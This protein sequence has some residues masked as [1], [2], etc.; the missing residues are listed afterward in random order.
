MGYGKLPR[1]LSFRGP[2]RGGVTLFLLAILRVT[3]FILLGFSQL[4]GRLHIPAPAAGQNVNPP[5]HIPALSEHPTG[6]RHPWL[7]SSLSSVNPQS[8]PGREG[9]KGEKEGGTEG[10]MGGRTEGRTE[11][12]K[13]LSLMGRLKKGPSSSPLPSILLGQVFCL[14]PWCWAQ[15][16]PRC[17]HGTITSTAK[18]EM[19]AFP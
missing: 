6:S 10:G 12:E 7:L 4:W 8:A 3:R 2:E 5:P 18:R 14:V 15:P 1:F 16:Q 11:G 17:A 9:D 19:K 13:C